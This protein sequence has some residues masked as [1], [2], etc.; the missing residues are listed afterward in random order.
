[1]NDPV[2]SVNNDFSNGKNYG[3]QPTSKANLPSRERILEEL[4]DIMKKLPFGS[5]WIRL[6]M[7][8]L[9]LHV[10]GEKRFELDKIIMDLY[11]SNII[12]LSEGGPSNY[13]IKTA[14]NKEL[15][16]NHTKKT[17][18]ILRNLLYYT[19][20]KLMIQIKSGH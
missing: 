3:S 1:M 7:F 17:S 8:Y 12:D 18:K 16:T 2:L 9:A 20:M 19:K 6:D 11:C 4:R 14:K 10:I 13:S 15:R 5:R